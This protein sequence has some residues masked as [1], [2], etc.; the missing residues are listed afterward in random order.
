MFSVLNKYK[1]KLPSINDYQNEKINFIRKLNKKNS[2]FKENKVIL[3]NYFK[4]YCKLKKNN[5]LENVDKIKSSFVNRREKMK[6]FYKEYTIIKNEKKE[7]S[8]FSKLGSLTLFFILNLGNFYLSYKK[9][10]YKFRFIRSIGLTS[11]L[12]LAFNYYDQKNIN[13]YI[14][15]K[16]KAHFSKMFS[17]I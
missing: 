6:T 13:R 8:N 14:E 1:E 17:D 15:R 2:N 11:S 4:D 3:Y 5:T 10:Y 7:I 16:R 9:R 12:C